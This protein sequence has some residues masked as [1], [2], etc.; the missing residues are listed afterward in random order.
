MPETEMTRSNGSLPSPDPFIAATHDTEYLHLRENIR[1]LRK[2]P[3]GP[4]PKKVDAVWEVYK[5]LRE[6]SLHLCKNL[7]HK[8]RKNHS[9]FVAYPHVFLLIDVEDASRNASLESSALGPLESRSSNSGSLT[10]TTL[11]FQ[12][13][14]TW[15]SSINEYKVVLE[16][17]LETLRISL[18]ATYRS[19]DPDATE[20]QL[21]A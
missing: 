9:A 8:S 5:K 15:L 7:L 10:E 21:E 18:L 4:D 11:P 20:R 19:Y 14:E 6:E 3:P 2:A 13:N 16:G 12:V 1:R 17:M